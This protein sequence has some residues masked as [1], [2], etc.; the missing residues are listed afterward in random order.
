MQNGGFRKLIYPLVMQLSKTRV[1]N[2]LV[3]KYVFRCLEKKT[4]ELFSEP[5]KGN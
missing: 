5:L 3:I 4:I 1:R 2:K